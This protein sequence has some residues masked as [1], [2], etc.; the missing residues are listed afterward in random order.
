MRRRS[1]MA[2]TVRFL[3]LRRVRP[4]L[5]LPIDCR[6]GLPLFFHG[7]WPSQTRNAARNEPQK[8]FVRAH[9]TWSWSVFRFARATLLRLRPRL[10]DRTSMAIRGGESGALY[11]HPFHVNNAFTVCGFLRNCCEQS[12]G[13]DARHLER[14]CKYWME[15][16]LRLDTL[17]YALF[18]NYDRCNNFSNNLSKRKTS[19]MYMFAL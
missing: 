8:S 11:K 1:A 19:S 9:V 14:Y 13:N 15:M 5:F 6:P 16:L 3:L 4:F 10:N 7:S 18:F 2:G 12:F 17:L